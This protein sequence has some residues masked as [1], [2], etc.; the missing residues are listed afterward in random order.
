MNDPTYLEASRTLAQRV[1]IE[2]GRSPERRAASIFRLATA[3]PAS[4]FEIRQLVALAK[5]QSKYFRKAPDEA[6]A[7][8]TNGE[9]AY[10]EKLPVADLATWTVVASTVLNLDETISKE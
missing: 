9:S 4:R 7:L 10:D 3:R 5:D 1:L 8:L 2:S 6:A